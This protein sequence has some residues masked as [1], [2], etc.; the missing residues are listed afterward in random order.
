MRRSV[1]AVPGGVV[2][3]ADEAAASA[4]SAVDARG[5]VGVGG[6]EGGEVVGAEDVGGGVLEGGEV[7][8][9]GAGPDVGGEHGGQMRSAVRA[10]VWGTGARS[11]KMRYS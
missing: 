9:A 1:V 11:G 6:G 8:A 3:G 5:E 10:E 2:D 4:S 7:E